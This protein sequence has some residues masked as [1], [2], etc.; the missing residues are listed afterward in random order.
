MGLF[1]LL[2]VVLQFV[3]S[4]LNSVT[5]YHDLVNIHQFLRH[6]ILF[7]EIVAWFLLQSEFHI[8]PKC[9]YTNWEENI[10]IKELFFA[11]LPIFQLWENN[12]RV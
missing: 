4:L 6:Q 12:Q 10:H 5:S 7:E 3:K 8:I 9:S 1:W 11:I 2:E